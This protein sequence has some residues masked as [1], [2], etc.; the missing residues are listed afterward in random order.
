MGVA[1]ERSVGTFRTYMLKQTRDADLL[2]FEE[3]SGQPLPEDPDQ[4]PTVDEVLD[5]FSLHWL[6]NTATSGARLYW[7]NRNHIISNGIRAYTSSDLPASNFC[8]KGN[9]LIR[10]TRE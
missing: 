1:F 9:S 6:T 2:L 8:A 7:E 5:N 3:I 4:T 10:P